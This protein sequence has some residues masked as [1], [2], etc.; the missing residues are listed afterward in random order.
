VPPKNGGGALDTSSAEIKQLEEAIK[1][2]ESWNTGTAFELESKGVPAERIYRA[3]RNVYDRAAEG[4]LAGYVHR[5]LVYT[6]RNGTRLL[7]DPEFQFFVPGASLEAQQLMAS[8]LGARI[9]AALGKGGPGYMLLTDD[10]LNLYLR[11]VTGEIA[12]PI[13][14]EEFMAAAPVLN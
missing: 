14:V 4:G 6:L 3:E 5:F 8:G 12:G 2:G 9:R 7:V 10:V 13:T 11:I 1:E